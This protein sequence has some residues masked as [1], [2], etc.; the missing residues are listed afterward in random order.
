MAWRN[1]FPNIPGLW[2]HVNLSAQDLQHLNL[3]AAIDRTLSQ[4]QLP[5]RYLTIEITESMLIEDIDSTIAVLQHSPTFSNILQHIK[6]RGIHISIDDFGTGY[7]S[8]GY[9]HHLFASPI[10]IACRWIV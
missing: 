5:V 3:L 6:S 10:C 8:L 9:L 1:R 7:S 2:V 4:T